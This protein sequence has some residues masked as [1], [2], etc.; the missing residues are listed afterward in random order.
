MSKETPNEQPL[1]KKEL[2]RLYKSTIK[3]NPTLFKDTQASDPNVLTLAAQDYYAA[4][5]EHVGELPMRQLAALR[6]RVDGFDVEVELQITG[7]YQALDILYA[8]NEELAMR[9]ILAKRKPSMETMRKALVKSF[10][11][12]APTAPIKLDEGAVTV[13]SAKLST[14]KP[15]YTEVASLK[16]LSNTA[17]LSLIVNMSK[18]ESNG[19]DEKFWHELLLQVDKRNLYAEMDTLQGC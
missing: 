17:I 15:P 6:K 2:T 10:T 3:P 9:A 1:T 11:T 16:Q 18:E 7:I 5:E 8:T 12:V 14:A 4:L 13:D 19:A